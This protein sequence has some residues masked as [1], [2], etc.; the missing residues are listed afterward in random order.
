MFLNIFR[1]AYLLPFRAKTK[2]AQRN[3]TALTLGGVIQSG[4]IIGCIPA[5]LP[6]ST[7]RSDDTQQKL[8]SSSLKST[9]KTTT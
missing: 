9:T 3:S 5:W 8:N 4:A 6:Y 7:H 1:I 2:I